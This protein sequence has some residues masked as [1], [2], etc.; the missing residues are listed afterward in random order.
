[1][2]DKL[3]YETSGSITWNPEILGGEG[4]RKKFFNSGAN[5]VDNILDINPIY[6]D[7]SH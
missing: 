2:I 3:E 6:V 7:H 5:F 1:M 4:R